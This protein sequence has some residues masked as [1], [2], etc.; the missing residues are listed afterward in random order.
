MFHEYNYIVILFHETFH[1]LFHEYN[2][3]QGFAKSDILYK[4][5]NDLRKLQRIFYDIK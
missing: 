1:E 5:E 4:V 3:I 2:Y